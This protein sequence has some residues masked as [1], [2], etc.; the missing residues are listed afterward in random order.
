[1]VQPFFFTVRLCILFVTMQNEM[2]IKLND[3]GKAR[4]NVFVA[5]SRCIELRSSYCCVCCSFLLARKFLI[6]VFIS[7]MCYE[8]PFQTLIN[9]RSSCTYMHISQALTVCR[10]TFVVVV[11]VHL[12]VFFFRLFACVWAVISRSLSLGFARFHFHFLA[13]TMKFNRRLH[14]YL[15][16][17]SF[18]SCDIYIRC[19]ISEWARKYG[20]FRFIHA[21]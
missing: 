10:A 15:A 9:T 7:A 6:A 14:F 13:V 4:T 3:C 18:Y 17:Y 16:F 1:M 8:L 21:I 20:H 19:M 2:K 12:L 11:F 5:L